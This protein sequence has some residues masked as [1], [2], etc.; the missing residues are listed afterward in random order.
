MCIMAQAPGLFSLFIRSFIV[1]M[2]V[3]FEALKC[4]F[5]FSGLSI[6]LSGRAR[7]HVVCSPLHVARRISKPASL[8]SHEYRSVFLQARCCASS[9]WKSKQKTTTPFTPVKPVSSPGKQGDRVIQN[10][11]QCMRDAERPTLSLASII[12][13]QIKHSKVMESSKEKHPNTDFRWN[14]IRFKLSFTNR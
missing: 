2:L 3:A 12:L 8:R 10:E 1:Y 9:P 11:D 7:S 5:P 6:F 13:S 4:R 14:S